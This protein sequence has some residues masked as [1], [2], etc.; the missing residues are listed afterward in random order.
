MLYH[1]IHRYQDMKLEDFGYIAQPYPPPS[2]GVF[3]YL[4]LMMENI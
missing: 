1:D 4:L 2:Y 3:L